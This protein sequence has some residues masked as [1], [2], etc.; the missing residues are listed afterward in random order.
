MRSSHARACYS[1]GTEVHTRTKLTAMKPIDLGDPAVAEHLARA[2]EGTETFIGR[3]ENGWGF[4]AIL[5]AA[6]WV[7]VVA[8]F[9][10]P[11]TGLLVSIFVALFRLN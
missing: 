8:G 4:P 6:T 5:T 11:T 1:F 2:L 3:V 9:M 10:T 7:I